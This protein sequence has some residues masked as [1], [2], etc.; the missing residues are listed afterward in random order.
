MSD[1]YGFPGS[2]PPGAPAGG[3]MPGPMP[4]PQASPM[5]PPLPST[6]MMDDPLLQM[7]PIPIKMYDVKI[8][9]C[10]KSGTAK[11]EPLPPDDFLCDPEATVLDEERVRFAGDIGRPTRSDLL[12][13]YPDKRKIIEDAPAYAARNEAQ[14]T[15]EHGWRGEA[16]RDP[17]QDQ[18]ELYEIYVKV[19]YETDIAEW[20]QVCMIGESGSREMLS[21]EPW[22]GPLPYTDLVPNPMPHRRRGRSLFE[23]LYDI[24]R[25]KTTVLRQ[26]LNNLYMVNNP[27]QVARQTDI[28]NPDVLLAFGI[29]DTVWS[30]GEAGNAVSI[31]S[32]P[33]V[34]KESFP[35]LE[36]LDMAAE[37]RTGIGRQSM[38]LDPQALQNQTATAA[39]ITQ[40]IKHSKVETY[41]R[42]I[43]EAG[44]LKRLFRCLLK[45]YASN[46]RA[47]KMIKLRNQ[48]VEMDPRSWNAEMD[49]TINVGLGAGSR[50]RDLA[51]LNA[52]AQK[53]EL[54]IQ[55]VG[56][57]FNPLLNI[58]HL[59][60]TYRKMAESA[61]LK[62][63][64][65]HFPELDD[66][67]LMQLGQLMK[68]G[69]TSP[70]QQKA[71]AQMQIEQMKIQ[72]Q[73]QIEGAKLQGEQALANLK[74][75]SDQQ[76]DANKGQ[77][78]LQQLQAK[79]E[80]ERLQAQADIETNNRK[81]AAE[82][83]LKQQE[84]ELKREIALL[85]FQL[86]EREHQTKLVTMRMQA[87]NDRAKHEMEMEGDG[88]DNDAVDPRFEE[89]RRT[90]EGNARNEQLFSR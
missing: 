7:P 42:N 41:A 65:I 57:P 32:V 69:K 77:L 19:A 53:Q 5:P 24:Q 80:I 63:P 45:I 84:F 73:G 54:V 27:R 1:P 16:N 8:K 46:Q 62:N 76:R 83:Q 50:D 25:I 49:C 15:R 71:Q 51:M 9:R 36:Y 35:M 61:G 47:P 72:A 3:A 87:V 4:P 60:D 21:N 90:D 55:H 56:D 23:D 81:V 59:F 40:D 31:L 30:R 64:E 17:S 33:P 28:I 6:P 38:A 82:M 52:V 86:K 85:E 79:A 48:W 89:K 44:G 29:G 74:M 10:I 2:Q 88:E 14:S 43:A 68:Q 12:R 70:E 26:Q 34:F 13:K 11:V 75:Q 18:L 78:D 39:N 66:Q 58:G 20:R 67:Q 37:K 22:G